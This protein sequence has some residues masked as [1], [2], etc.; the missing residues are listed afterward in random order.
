[1]RKVIE[2]DQVVCADQSRQGGKVR[3]SRGGGDGDRGT[4]YAFQPPFQ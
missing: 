1:M 3:Q 2:Q 4:E